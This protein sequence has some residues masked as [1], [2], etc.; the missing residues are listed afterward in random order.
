MA[1]TKR[2]GVNGAGAIGSILSAHLARSGRE[3]VLIESGPRFAQV[4][5]HG[6]T[7]VGV[8]EVPTQRPHLLASV[9]ELRGMPVE[10]IFVCTKAWSLPSLLPPLHAALDPEA[11]VV[12]YQNGIGPE[13]EV[14][15]RFGAARVCRGIVNYAGGVAPGGDRVTVAWSTPP[16]YIGPLDQSSDRAAELARMLTAAGLETKAITAHEVKKG[17]FWKAILNAGLSAL[18]SSTGITMRRA[19]ALKHTR[20]LAERLVREGIQVGAAIGLDYGT[21]AVADAMAYLDRG[22]DHMPSMWTD[23]QH[24]LPTEIDSINGKIVELGRKHPSLDVSAN[25]FITAMIV[26]QEIKSGARTPDRIPDY[27]TH[28]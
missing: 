3:V 20:S 19:M 10:A 22:G 2:I 25:A 18:C 27:L 4:K 21:N 24:N 26:T 1:T 9:D 15:A 14:A 5:E 28:S 6:L 17:V 8:L 7:L 12:S 11:V 16:N 13:E 23:L